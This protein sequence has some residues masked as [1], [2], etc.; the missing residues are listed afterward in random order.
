[1]FQASLPIKFWGEAIL[2]SAY[3]INRTPSA[4]LNNQSPHEVLHATTPSFDQLKVFGCLCYMHHRA[5]DKDKFSARS[6]RCI[7]VGYPY[8]QKGWK[9]YDLDK[10][11]FLISRDVIFH[12][13]IF[14]FAT[15]AVSTPKSKTSPPVIS[16]TSDDDWLVQELPVTIDRGSSD[17]IVTTV[18]HPVNSETAQ[19]VT[20]PTEHS[21][22]S[23]TTEQSPDVSHDAAPRAV[24]LPVPENIT[25][26]E[27]L[28]RGHRNKV[29]PAKFQDYVSH[30]VKCLQNPEETHL[31]LNCS[32]SLPSE[33]IQGKVLYP[34]SHYV[35]N[36][37]FS[38]SQ[39]TFLA[40]IT[41][42]TEPKRYSEAIKHKVWCDSMKDE[43]VAQE[44]N[45]TW[46]VTSLPPGK[47]VI[48]CQWIYRIKYNTDGTIRRHKSRLVACGK[49]KK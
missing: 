44:E 33:T 10:K 45:G 8:N 38:E 28:G 30:T 41:T 26:V 47:K 22:Q 11:E 42:A 1:M 13:N 14:P 3:L 34:V 6:R 16:S 17:D 49:N 46:D 9:V 40:A 32:T 7:F 31:V 23:E 21:A 12:E 2:T 39:Q 20:S 4:V 36:L 19:P 25:M 27:S 15:Q 43:I 37:S 29:P 24:Q 18:P 35:T 5:R 48:P